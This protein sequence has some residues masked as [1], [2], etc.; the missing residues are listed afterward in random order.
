M[1]EEIKKLLGLLAGAGYE[2]FSSG[3]DGTIRKD[4]IACD[5]ICVRL[6]IPKPVKTISREEFDKLTPE[7][8][9]EFMAERGRIA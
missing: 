6:T 3:V 7:Q 4:G 8:R 2:V 5:S 9:R 1:N